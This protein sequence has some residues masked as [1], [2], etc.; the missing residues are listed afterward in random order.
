M[1]GLNFLDPV[2]DLEEFWKQP[3][4]LGTFSE[5]ILDEDSGICRFKHHIFIML[6]VKSMNSR[7]DFHLFPKLSKII[8][9][10]SKFFTCVTKVGLLLKHA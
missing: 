5:L 4:P 9:L 8:E 2:K 6:N 10:F 7:R 1:L 3:L